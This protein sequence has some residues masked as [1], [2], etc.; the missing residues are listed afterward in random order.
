MEVGSKTL[1]EKIDRHEKNSDR[2]SN[3]GSAACSGALTT[4]LAA[5]FLPLPYISISAG[6]LLLGATSFILSAREDNKS[7]KLKKEHEDAQKKLEKLEKEDPS[8]NKYPEYKKSKFLADVIKKAREEVN[9]E[10]SR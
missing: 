1:K 2:L 9:N 8:Y 5:F 6:L 7:L 3:L 10:R 4:S